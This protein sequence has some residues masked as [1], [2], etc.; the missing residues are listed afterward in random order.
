MPR[1]GSVLCTVAGEFRSWKVYTTLPG[2]NSGRETPTSN[3][4]PFTFW[5]LFA[6]LWQ[7]RQVRPLATFGLLKISWPR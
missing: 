3:N 7:P 4:V 1:P 6:A 2:P 5:P